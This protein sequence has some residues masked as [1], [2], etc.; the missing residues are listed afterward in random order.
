MKGTGEAETKRICLAFQFVANFEGG[1]FTARTQSSGSLI[2][3]ELGSF[4][5]FYSNRFS[6]ATQYSSLRRF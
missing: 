3:L 6:N 2:E 5:F 4:F 1:S